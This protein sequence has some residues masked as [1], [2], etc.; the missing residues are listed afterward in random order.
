MVGFI[1]RHKMLSSFLALIVVTVSGMFARATAIEADLSRRMVLT[2][3]WEPANPVNGATVLFSVRSETP[4]KILSG[5]WLDRHVFFNFDAENGA[6]YGLAGVGLDSG[7]GK[8]NLALDYTFANNKRSSSSHAVAISRGRYP[9]TKLRVS[10]KYT[11]PEAE[12]LARIKEEQVLKREVFRL[13]SKQRLWKGRFAK[14]VN[15]VM[16][17]VFGARRTFNGR[18]QSVHQGLDFRAATGTPVQ[19]M[20]SGE[21]ILA[22]ELFYEGGFVVIDH[23]QGLLT[24]YMH[25]SEIKTK[26]G[27]RIAKGQEIALSGGTGRVTAPH[28]HTSVRWQGLYLDPA[29]LLNLELP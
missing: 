20:N 24:M 7:I 16:T 15:D 3:S 19:A 2:V 17:S 21:V 8:H 5:R 23:G 18:V 11:E 9:S 10:S 13:I 12:T 26:E 4:L 28:L 29:T 22:Q 6:W 14:P 27:D 25:L 1:R